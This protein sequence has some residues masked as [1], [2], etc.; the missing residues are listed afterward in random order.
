MGAQ[1]EKKKHE[2]F[3]DSRNGMRITGV[4]EVDS[5]D[6]QAVVLQT[7]EGEM[8]VE[9]SQLKI[10]TLDTDSGLVTVS[11]RIDAIYYSSMTSEP[12]K[13]ILSRIFK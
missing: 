1:T 3:V 2:I 11:G 12:K 9:G 13:G 7:S 8:T 4:V 6:E 10:G 5:F